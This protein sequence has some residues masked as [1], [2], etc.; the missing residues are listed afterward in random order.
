MQ[1]IASHRGD[2]A[3]L[4]VRWRTDITRGIVYLLKLGGFRQLSG[5][6]TYLPRRNE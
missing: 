5:P 2:E 4:Y 3:D 6:S 1:G